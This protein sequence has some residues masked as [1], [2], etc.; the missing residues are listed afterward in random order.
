M[1]VT[2]EARAP[3]KPNDFLDL[4]ALLSDEE[5]DMRDMVR[6]FVAERVT[7]HV[8]DWFEAATFPT[9]ELAPA[10]GR[11]GLLGM[12]LTGYGC[13]GASATAYGLA[14]MELEAA[15]A[16]SSPSR[17]RWRCSRSGAG[18]RRSRSR[19]GCRGWRRG[20]RSAASA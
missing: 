10:L 20:R 14:C 13:A 11:L 17:A 2:D 6:R 8:G 19:S 1:A 15:C 7:P 12:H 16:R 3:I 9:A 18:A 5:R 4:D